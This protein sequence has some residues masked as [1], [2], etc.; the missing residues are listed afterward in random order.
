MS[1]IMFLLYLK[2][3]FLVFFLDGRFFF[4]EVFIFEDMVL[5]LGGNEE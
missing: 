4:F 1:G 3:K 5:Y 2:V